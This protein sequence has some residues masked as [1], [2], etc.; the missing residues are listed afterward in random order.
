MNVLIVG[1]GMY[2]SGRGTDG[3]GTILPAL[4]KWKQEGSPLEDVFI[5]GMRPDSVTQTK[6]KLNQLNK[7]MGIDLHVRFFPEEN[8]VDNECYKIAIKEISKTACA[9]VS[10]PDHLHRKIAGDCLE[11][12]LHTLVVKP[13]TP[14]V[15]EAKELIALQEK[16]GVYGATEFHKRF[17]RAN[18]KLKETIAHGKIGDPLYFLVEYSQQKSIPSKIFSSWVNKSNIFQ[19]L[20]VHYVDI[21]Y[22][23]TG[24][25]PKRV[26]TNSQYGWLKDQGID[27]YD[28]IHATIEWE[29]PSKKNFISFIHTNW[30]DPESTSAL[31]DQQIKVIG[32]KGRYESD[33]KNRGIKI[34]TD[35]Q[36]FE[37]PNPDFCTTYPISEEF[38]SYQGYGIESIHTFLKD[39]LDL[40]KKKTTIE[41]LEKKRPTFKQSLVSTAVV[42]AVNTGLENQGNWVEIPKI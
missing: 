7:L 23:A 27:T 25:I 28:A 3:F 34:V 4:C 21:I 37:E 30:I 19:Y 10:V 9:I 15:K 8:H 2:V 14:T 33:Q 42:E 17:D 39:V 24:A 31:S 6:E 20:G 26:Q 16:H 22:F 11:A 35:D 5:A 36:G 1:L 13:L 40:I 41:N 38:T 29:L 18:L 12:G 32:T